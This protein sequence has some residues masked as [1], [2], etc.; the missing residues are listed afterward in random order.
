VELL[1]KKVPGEA[2]SSRWTKKSGD[3]E[4]EKSSSEHE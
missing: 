1:R 3:D 4:A 2:E